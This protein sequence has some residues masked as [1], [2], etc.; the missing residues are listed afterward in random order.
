MENR[1]WAFLTNH[2]RVF[3][4]L[5][6]HPRNTAQVIAQ[7]V[8]LSIR[9]VQKIID[10]LESGGYLHRR[11][12]GRCNH[13]IIHPEMPLRHRLAIEP[14]AEEVLRPDRSRPRR[15]NHRKGNYSGP[16]ILLKLEES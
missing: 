12:V 7:D 4:Y 1:E 6:R 15:G 10:D 5:S 16:A 3:I 11:K 9:A 8:G 13:Y 14:V 2:G